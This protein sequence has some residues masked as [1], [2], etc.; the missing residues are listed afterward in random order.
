MSIS[1]QDNNTMVVDNEDLD[2]GDLYDYSRNNNLDFI[3]RL[4]NTYLI[5]GNLIL[6][7]NTHLHDKDVSITIVGPLFQIKR[8]CTLE[9]GEFKNNK[10]RRGCILNMPYVLQEFGFGSIE[11]SESGNLLAYNS[12]INIYGYWSFFAG[13]N[14]VELIDCI[15]DGYGKVS[16]IDSVVRDTT[17][18]RSHGIYGT[19][20][21]EGQIKQYENIVIDQV[22]PATDETGD[23][24]SN[25]LRIDKDNTSDNLEI[26]YGELSGYSNLL[27]ILDT[28]YDYD[29]IMYG[30]KVN[31]GYGIDRKDINKNNFYH[32]YRFSPRF[33]NDEGMILPN[34]NVK[35]TN[36]LGEIEFEGVTDSNG[37][38]D[39]WLTY[40][41]DLKGP[42]VGET[43]SPHK[44]EIT[45]D[46]TT[47]LTAIIF[48]DRNMEK[49]PILLYTKI[50]S[51]VARIENVVKIVNE[52]GIDNVKQELAIANENIRN[53]VL[54]LG[55]DI[56]ASTSTIDLPGG[57]KIII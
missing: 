20:V 46:Q 56:K 21:Y 17:F 8:G 22:E 29:I 40:Y 39:C 15:I 48:I 31:D 43:M 24:K 10:G 30:T 19:I 12:L 3:D 4:S 28:M 44:V 55:K 51:D 47:T 34:V 52:T 18:K 32:K 1:I 53:I 5:K 2:F 37:Y 36:K 16:G 50:A 57:T 9:L 54:G 7:N 42:A 11:T 14:K 26:Y 45:L 49:F 41:R 23:I 38:I 6:Q 35:I 27:T 25:L 33:Q 13:D